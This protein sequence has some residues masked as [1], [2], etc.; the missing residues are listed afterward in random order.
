MHISFFCTSE[1]KT[2]IGFAERKG[3]KNGT[4]KQIKLEHFKYKV[5]V[6][7]LEFLGSPALLIS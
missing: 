4:L 3:K 7:A 5:F 6:G 1:K 2:E